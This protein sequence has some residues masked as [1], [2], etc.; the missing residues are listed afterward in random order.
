MIEPW[1]LVSFFQ[2]MSTNKGFTLIEIVVVVTVVAVIMVSII[3]VVVSTFKLQNQTKSNSKLVSGGN[4]IL[5]EIK[6]NILNSDSSTIVCSDDHSS[7][8]F[9]NDFDGDSS[10][11]S[12]TG[13]KIAS[14]SARTVYLNGE[15]ITVTDCSNFVSCSTLPSLEVSGVEFKFGVG[16]S[17]SGVGSG[18][19]FE[20][21]VTLRK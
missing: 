10:M 7:V 4:E 5:N 1:K 13:G 6:K 18:Q 9:I 8:A 14:I 15:D 3:G 2:E 12:C 19:D 17:T 16:T 11:I 20:M 21:N